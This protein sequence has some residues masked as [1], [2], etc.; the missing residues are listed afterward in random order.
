MS[1]LTERKKQGTGLPA[2]GNDTWPCV[3]RGDL[4]D[5][6]GLQTR[7]CAHSLSLYWPTQDLPRK[8]MEQTLEFNPLPLNILNQALLKC[9]VPGTVGR[10]KF[11]LLS[12]RPQVK[13]CSNFIC[14][15]LFSKQGNSEVVL[16]ISTPKPE[17]SI[18]LVVR[19]NL[20]CIHNKAKI[21]WRTTFVK[22]KRTNLFM[23]PIIINILSK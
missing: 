19:K 23:D 14:I 9:V 13:A 7:V 10:L 3:V 12:D 2:H 18:S 1:S 11:K 15:P 20:S 5:T 17:K 4:R 16:N 21:N 8:P 6:S 22:K